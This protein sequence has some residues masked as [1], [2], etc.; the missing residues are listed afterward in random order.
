VSETHADELDS[1]A[2]YN[3]L[4]L[5]LL[6]PFKFKVRHAGEPDSEASKI[7]DYS[8]HCAAVKTALRVVLWLLFKIANIH[9]NL[10]ILNF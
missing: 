2:T 5:N 10:Q 9:P 6:N 4:S 7:S 1:N 3:Q 8:A